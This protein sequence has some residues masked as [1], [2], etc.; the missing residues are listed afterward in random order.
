MKRRQQNEG[1]TGKCDDVTKRSKE[2]GSSHVNEQLTKEIVCPICY[3][4][5]DVANSDDIN[6]AANRH[7]DRCIRRST[8]AVSYSHTDDDEDGECT[9]D[10]GRDKDKKEADFRASLSDDG[11][12]DDFVAPGRETSDEDTDLEVDKSSKKQKGT[13]EVSS[14]RVK[15]DKCLVEDDWETSTYLERID[16]CLQG[17]SSEYVEVDNSEAANSNFGRGR[18]YE[19]FYVPRASWEG[20]YDYQKGGV[21]WMWNLQAAETGGILGDEMGL[22]KVSCE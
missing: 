2:G 8:P 20:T 1:S 16:E 7:I 12:T 14:G 22:G 5:F 3:R 19:N 17:G 11:E 15:E 4:L 6:V 9:D 21:Q 13:T 18:R 10:V